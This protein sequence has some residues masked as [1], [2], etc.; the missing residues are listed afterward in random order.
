MERRDKS[1][2]RWACFALTG[3]LAVGSP[4]EAGPGDAEAIGLWSAD[5]KPIVVGAAEPPSFRYDGE[6]IHLLLVCKVS[7]GF[8][9]PRPPDSVYRLRASWRGDDLY[10]LYP[11]GQWSYIA[12]FENGQFVSK[13]NQGDWPMHKVERERWV[14][15]YLAQDRER[16]H[17]PHLAERINLAEDHTAETHGSFEASASSGWWAAGLGL[18]GCLLATFLVP[19]RRA[20]NLNAP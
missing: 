9:T 3:L 7:I 15:D 13:N 12:T 20:V 11:Y 6:T 2:S 8:M 16:W 1:L 19:R 18:V 4:V 5:K 14:D 17:Y 10:C